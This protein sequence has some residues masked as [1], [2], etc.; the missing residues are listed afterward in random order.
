MKALSPRRFFDE[1]YDP[2]SI[3]REERP[4]TAGRRSPAATVARLPCVLWNA[5]SPAN[6]DIGNAVTVGKAK[7][8]TRR[9]IGRDVFQTPT[10]HGVLAGIDQRHLPRFAFGGVIFD[11][12]VARVDRYVGSYQ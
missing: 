1:T 4:I 2:V 3:H 8:L 9:E 12:V 6:V 11:F 10:G 7:R 5:T